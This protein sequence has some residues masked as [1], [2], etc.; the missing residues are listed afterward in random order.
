M[1]NWSRALEEVGEG[2][3][4]QQEL[5]AVMYTEAAQKEANRLAGESARAEVST[6][7]VA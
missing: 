2:L 3:I 1:A 6:S 5:G 4:R 7:S